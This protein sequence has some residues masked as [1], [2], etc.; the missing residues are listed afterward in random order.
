MMLAF[1]RALKKY[2]LSAFTRDG[3]APEQVADVI[4]RA[5][6]RPCGKQEAV[7][8]EGWLRARNIERLVH[9][10]ALKNVPHILKHGLIPREYLELE[11]VRM[12][13]GAAFSDSQRHDA[14]PQFSC[15]S[16]TSPNYQMFYNKRQ[17]LRGGWAV[18]SFAPEALTRLYF[19]FTPTNAA[20]AG[21]IAQAGMDGAERLFQLDNVRQTLGLASN[22]TTDPQAEALCDSILAPGFVLDVSVERPQDQQW[23]R[24]RGIA[25]RLDQTL[26][27]P[28]RDW[29]FW[30]QHH[31]VIQLPDFRKQHAS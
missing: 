22:E 5:M 20:A 27:Q 16:I 19:Q 9:F 21:V 17:R 18:I 12:G 26:F 10:T 4:C 28:R 3:M 6:V 24:A 23:L 2:I 1:H 8:F 29:Q 11:V 13:L 15:L 7:A 25:A 14:M 30:R 31:S